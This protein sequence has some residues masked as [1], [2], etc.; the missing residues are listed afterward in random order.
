MSPR[1]S[2]L[3]ASLR[4]AEPVLGQGVA[5]TSGTGRLDV[6]ALDVATTTGYA[7]G[8]V[9]GIPI[10]GSVKFGGRSNNPNDVFS[11]AMHWIEQ[12]LDQQPRPDILIIESLLPGNAKRGFTSKAVHDRLAGLHGIVRA[13]AG[14][15]GIPQ[16]CEAAVGDV[17]QHFI[18]DRHC[19]SAKAKNETL[20]QCRALGWPAS[21]HDAADALATWSF[22]CS[23]IDPR[24]ALRLT[25]LFGRLINRPQQPEARGEEG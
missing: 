13:V 5:E 23:L 15:K 10:A 6:L 9:G 3:A 2:R 7:R 8:L 4:S 17:R 24:L 12:K 18:G 20:L 22:A 21:D 25:P 14:D 16:V 11:D 19:K 1:S